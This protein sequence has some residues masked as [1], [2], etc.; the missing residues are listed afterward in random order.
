M[1][2]VKKLVCANDVY[3]RG[4][5]GRNVRIALL[6]TGVYAGHPDLKNR[7]ICFKDF[8]NHKTFPYDDNG[9]GTHIAGIMCANGRV[10]ERRISGM[11]PGAELIV[12][13]VLDEKGNGRTDDVLRAIEWI[14]NNHK[15]YNIRL[16]NFS[17]GFLSRA[18]RREQEALLGAIDGLW[19]EDVMVITAAGNNG[20]RAHTV[21][22]PGIS[23]RVVTVGACDDVSGMAIDLQRGYSGKGPTGCC[24]V[25]P[26]ILAPGTKI[27]SLSGDSNGYTRKSGTSMAAPVVCGALA[28]AFEKN[29]VLT[30]AE[31]KLKLYETVTPPKPESGI[32]AW[33]T[34]H[35][36]NLMKML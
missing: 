24:I 29:P 33:G 6:D 20:P 32:K 30:P 36:D 4:Y 25:K 5:T 22:V 19:D 18:N 28:L 1:N 26:E 11:A 34:L 23:R 8:V 13:K 7:V 15:I 2:R 17:V 21:T 16:L 31:L 14:S 35:V 12:L 3:K 27:L 9:H 10:S